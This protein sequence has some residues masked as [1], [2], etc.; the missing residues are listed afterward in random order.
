M[1]C[2]N[3]TMLIIAVNTYVFKFNSYYTAWKTEFKIPCNT[4]MYK[5]ELESVVIK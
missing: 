3:P 1:V 5:N 2:C 4:M